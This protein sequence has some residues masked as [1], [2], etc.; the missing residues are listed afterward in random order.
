M[1]KF[2]AVM[3]LITVLCVLAM[4]VRTFINAPR[5]V[6]IEKVK[7][8]LLWAV[9]QAETDLGGGTGRLKLRQVYDMF[10]QRFPIIAQAV[11]F[12]TFSLWV[13]D[14][15]LEMKKLI[16]ENKIVEEMIHSK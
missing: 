4:C 14:A 15:L 7:E 6:Q 13:D 11:S 10:V 5:K 12:G 16:S 9:I 8:W 2:T 3:M 1:D